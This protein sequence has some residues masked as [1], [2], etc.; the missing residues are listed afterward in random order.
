MAE[1]TTA[2]TAATAVA[3]IGVAGVVLGAIL[4]AVLTVLR[5]LIVDR[6]KAKKDK[7]YLVILVSTQLDRFVLGCADVVD[8]DGLCR[9]QPDKDGCR[10]AQTT[11]PSFKP[12][13]LQVDWKSLPVD[14]MHRVL[15]FPFAIEQ[16][17][18]RLQSIGED[19]DPPDYADWFD[20][21]QFAYANLASTAAVLADD[22]R[23]AV[24]VPTRPAEEWR[25]RRHILDRLEV[26]NLR[27]KRLSDKHF[28]TAPIFGHPV[29]QGDSI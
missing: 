12:E 7:Q 18:A 20:E 26:I 29:V 17:D 1:P 5:E 25:T 15:D 6:A 23:M 8:D 4:G 11:P 14:L 9:G 27:R 28:L 3:W 22:L 21:R 19:S 24:G 16:V 13:L 10:A 2:S